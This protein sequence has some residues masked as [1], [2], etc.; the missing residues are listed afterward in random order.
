M[1]RM[2]A[3]IRGRTRCC[4]AAQELAGAG[5]ATRTC[6]RRCSPGP[7]RC[8]RPRTAE[9][10]RA[11]RGGVLD[12]RHRQPRPSGVPRRAGLPA[13]AAPAGVGL[14]HH[15]RAFLALVAALRY[16]A[17]PDAPFLRRRGCCWT[18]RR[19]RR[20]EVLGVALRLA[21]TLCGG[22]PGL[23]WPAP[24]C[25]C[26]GGRLVLRLRRTAACSPAR[27]C[28]AGWRRWRALGLEAVVEVAGTRRPDR[29]CSTPSSQ[30][31]SATARRRFR[32]DAGA[33]AG[34]SARSRLGARACGH[35]TRR[36]G[37]GYRARAA[38]R[39]LAI[40]AWAGRGRHAPAASHGP[41]DPVSRPSRPGSP[42][43]R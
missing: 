32:P 30:G 21:Y 35:G 8:S 17:E 20:A 5:A 31:A 33:D 9:A 15:A 3:A 14:D 26:R 11:A 1:Q 16:E 40:V 22:T 6:R 4:A 10:R 27:A 42:A 37:A 28:C 23:C 43:C 13:G 38:P 41:R 7:I 18:C 34:T 29:A 19:T 36:T 12:V 25:G 39:T 24:R 2:P